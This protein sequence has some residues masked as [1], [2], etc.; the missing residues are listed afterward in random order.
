MESPIHDDEQ[1]PGTRFTVRLPVDRAGLSDAVKVV[2]HGPEDALPE[3]SAGEAEADSV[4]AEENGNATRLYLDTLPLVLVVE[5][6]ADIRRFIAEGLEQRYRVEEAVDGADALEKA[7][8]LSPDLVVT[9]LMMP[10]M[11]GAELCRTL[12]SNMETSHIP[13]VM[14]TAKGSLEHQIE[15]L[16]TGADDYITKPFHMVIL[17]TRIANLLASRKLLREQFSRDFMVSD[18]PLPENTP[19]QEFLRKVFDVLDENYSDTEFA[20]EQ[21]AQQL[22]MSLSTLQRKLK[23]LLDETPAKLIWN[24]RLKK[25]TGVLKSTDLRI[26]EVAF[27]VGYLDPNHF[28]RQFKQLYGMTPSTYRTTNTATKSE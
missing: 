2:L 9:D 3:T 18:H 27:E 14:L 1:G 26:S 17:Q 13:V 24:V 25:S 4:T 11:D 5:D 22:G 12:K 15:G 23:S 6:D 16:Q 28:S 8:R 21:F 20:V 19:D 10:V 7:N